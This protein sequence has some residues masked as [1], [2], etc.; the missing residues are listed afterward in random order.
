MNIFT[1]IINIFHIHNNIFKTF[2]LI[3]TP[4]YGKVLQTRHSEVN[5][6]NELYKI[7]PI[8]YY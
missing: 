4:L 7:I 2:R 1:Y 5:N 8:Y 3:L 6:N